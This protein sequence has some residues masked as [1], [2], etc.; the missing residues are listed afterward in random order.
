[1]LLGLKIREKN[2]MKA[3]SA[4]LPGSNDTPTAMSEVRQSQSIMTRSAARHNAA[5]V[6]HYRSMFPAN[7]KGMP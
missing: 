6:R 7:Q 4:A 1:L 2:F 5:F 3:Y